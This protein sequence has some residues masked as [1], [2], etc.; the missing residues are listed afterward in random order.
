MLV[1]MS[2]AS[3]D[4]FVLFF[5]L[6]CAYAYVTSEDQALRYANYVRNLDH[7]LDV[8]CRHLQYSVSQKRLPWHH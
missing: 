4:F 8:T 1:L 6:S 5:V 2:Y 3:V 7:V